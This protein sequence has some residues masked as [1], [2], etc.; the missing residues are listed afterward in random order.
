MLQRLIQKE[1]ERPIESFQALQTHNS[2]MN[3]KYKNSAVCLQQLV[4][5]SSYIA[6]AMEQNKI[7]ESEV[8]KEL[9]RLEALLTE[10]EVYVDELY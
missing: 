8:D 6:Q 10:L 3:E 1:F 5:T 4:M 7:A 2:R 9:D